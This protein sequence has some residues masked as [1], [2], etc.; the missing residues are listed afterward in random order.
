M[1]V[2]ARLARLRPSNFTLLTVAGLLVVLS[3]FPLRR[4]RA[5]G[6]GATILPSV[7]KPLV[8]LKS[9]QTAKIAYTG[10]ASAV[11]A[12]K[13]G[14]AVPTALASADFDADGAVD[15][16]AGYSTGNA[17]VI[18]LFRG[19]KDAFSPTD[20]TLYPKAIKGSIAATFLSKAQAFSVPESPDL[21]ATGDFN[22][23]GHQDVLVASRGGKLYFLAGDGNGNLLAPTV[24][25]VLGQMRALAADAAGHVAV[26]LESSTGEELAV[27]SPSAEGLAPLAT[28]PLPA[29]GDSIAWGS[30]G[31]SSDIA[32]AAGSNIAIIYNPLSPK[33]QTETVTVPF[34]VKA[35]AVGDYIWDQ[36][37][38]T[39]IAAL[40]D[41]GSIQILQHGVLNTAP[42]TGAQLQGRRQIFSAKNLKSRANQPSN[43]T[44]LGKWTIAKQL[45][46]TVS[47]PSGLVSASAFNTPRLAATPTHDV[48]VL[49]AGKSQLN[50]FDTSGT[51]A[52]PSAAVS[53]NAPPVAALALPQKIDAA[54]DIVVLTSSTSAPMLITSD[55]TLTLN[56]NTT[57]DIDGVGSASACATISNVTSAPSTLS[58][59]EAVCIANNNG[60]TAVTINVPAGTYDLAISTFGGYNSAY[61]SGELQVGIQPGNNITISGA[62]QGSTI[63]QQTN[64]KDRLIEQDEEFQGSIPIT[65]QNLTL[66]GGDCTDA[67]GLDCVDSGGGAI[68][69]G[70]TG[71]NM[72]ITNVTL[73]NNQ[74]NPSGEDE[75]GGAITYVGGT[76]TV[77]GSTF[78][79]NTATAFGGAVFA[80]VGYDYTTLSDIP[81]NFSFVNSTFTNNTAK[82]GSGGGI[83]F[84]MAAGYPSSVSGSTFTGNSVQSSSELGGA[85][86]AAGND[87]GEAFSLSNSRI[88]GNTA[89]GGATGLYI[90]LVNPTVNNNWWGCNAGPNQSGC[91]SILQDV[92]STNVPYAPSTWL[93]LSISADPTQ[94]LSNGTSTLSADLTHNN[95]GTGGFSVPNG[96]PITFDGTLDSSVNPTS[97]TLTGGTQTS[98]YTAGGSTGNGTG[99]AT[100][101]NQTV[102]AAITI[103]APPSFTS[104][105]ST[106]FTVG[107]NGSFPVTASG[108]PTPTVTQT[109]GSTPSGVSFSGGTGSGT[110]SGTPA[111][112]TG[113]V[114][115][116]D[117][118]AANGFGSDA[119][120]GFTLTV[121]Q[122]PSITSANNASFTFNTFNTFTVTPAAGT[123]PAATFSES[124]TLPNG[125]TLNMTTGVLSGTPTQPGSFPITITAGNGVGSAATQS[126]TLNVSQASTSI[127]VTN[128]SLSPEDYGEDLPVTITAVLSWTGSGPSPTA[129]N[130]TIGGNGPSGYGAT[131]CGAPSSDT[132]TCTATYTPTASD[133]V[134]SYT[135]SASFSGDSNYTGSSSSQNDN[136]SIRQEQTSTYV[137][138][139]QNPSAL[140]QPVTFTAEIA[141]SQM[142]GIVR[143]NGA[144][145]SGGAKKN[146]LTRKG[147]SPAVTTP[148]IGG[149]V[150]WS[151]NTGCGTTTLSGETSQC[152]TSTLPEGTD[153][154]TATY[155]GDTNHSGSAGTLSGG[156]VV[157]PA[158]T[159]TSI[160]VTSVSPS[161][162]VYGQDASVTIMAVLSWTGSGPSPTAGNVSIGGNGPS[163]YG[164]TSCGAPSGDT[165]T[166]TATYTPTGVDTVGTYTETASFSGDSNY[167]GSSSSQNNNFSITQASSSTSVGSSQ[168]PSLVGQQ[169]TF[170]ATIDGQYGLVVQRNGAVMSGA[171]NKKSG[172]G[173]R[174]SSSLHPVPIGGFGGTVM[175]SLNTG[176]GSTTVSGDP[177]TTQCVTTTLPEGN[178][179]IT[180]S[181][182]GDTNHSGSGG[183]LSGGQQV[184]E[185]MV[186]LTPDSMDFGT[187]YLSSMVSQKIKVKNTGNA[188]LTITGVTLTGKSGAGDFHFHNHCPAMV[189]AGETCGI[190]VFF[191]A[192]QIGTRSNTLNVADDAPGSPQQAG[193]TATVI[194]PIATFNPTQVSFGTVKQGNHKTEKVTITNTGTTE[195]TI[196]SIAITGADMGD[197][198]QTNACTGIKSGHKC[199]VEVTFTP[200]MTGSR[201]ADLT[202]TDNTQAGTTNIPLMGMGQTSH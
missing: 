158:V 21:L 143:R 7:G 126:F 56:V 115:T 120:Q 73:S 134:G 174:P 23:D 1:L 196:G 110:L 145:M 19:N 30:L 39:E 161:S 114:Y 46:G 202:V 100:V 77:T 86:E 103:G 109:G 124:G 35:I 28:F 132:L 54:R 125:V 63:I 74:S 153:T 75:N 14:T 9:P 162:E 144:L 68:L 83:S 173:Q 55:V 192:N 16:V 121:D 13:G 155:S 8:N 33:A 76:L 29:R 194:N 11:A 79:S 10:D 52:S 136:F 139:G 81:S 98:T 164:A 113:G 168:N 200:T 193:F 41:D 180:A 91:D 66:T 2:H 149:S 84:S 94:I 148:A 87:T 101:D 197:F 44:S 129:G 43:P 37:A 53:F 102:S 112:G 64:G 67:S 36:S 40:A 135:E 107:T 104:G 92:S 199:V 177:G 71:D 58:L 59:R 176:C 179:T 123:Y 118:Q 70:G 49:D 45:P 181:Y 172:F 93:V 6:A 150:T 184:N 117:F 151:S 22:R 78:S 127:A 38:R 119:T 170:T 61:S 5:A 97:T 140:G 157:N 185:P 182:S 128:V 85:I 34:G 26:S 18:V 131:S 25:P 65:I 147:S 3:Y 62:G 189:P 32:V 175:W 160:T 169:V 188:P 24:V 69:G 190:E 183:T 187:L 4:I 195:L 57:A 47:A 95:D 106:T 138:S 27:F 146:G 90:S 72:T 31:G 178:N 80:N 186:M 159:S 111:P 108:S 12:L 141:P 156:Q 42:L 99:T 142:G 15:V 96:T 154:I 20:P 88:A 167:S 50:I 130:V 152:T 122:A 82:T 89:A 171:V 165:L 137:D 163:G 48:M 60:A 51:A 116:L 198:G 201:S 105:S 166:C 133:T 191:T 17:G